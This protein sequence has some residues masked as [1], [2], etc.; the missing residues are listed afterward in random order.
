MNFFR[1]IIVFTLFGLF[2]NSVF[3]Q[4]PT[5]SEVT[6]FCSDD[7]NSLIFPNTTNGGQ[8]E[9]G[10]NY[11]CLGSTPNP[12]WYYLQID[13]PGD[14]DFN[15]VQNSQPDFSGF[16]IDVDFIAY[17]PFT[18]IDVCNGV[19]LSAANTI[20][21]SFSAAAVENFTINNAEPDQIYILLIT[22]F[23]NQPGFIQLQQTNAGGADDGS[24]DCSI[25]NPLVF[26]EGDV[27][28]LDATTTDAVTY[29]WTQ[30]GNPLAE[31]G[32][33]LNN[34]MAP[35]AVYEVD[36][37]NAA[38]DVIGEIQFNVNFE[39]IPSVNPFTPPSECDNNDDGVYE[40][41]FTTLNAI[42]TG[43]Q[44][45][46]EIS[47]HDSLNDAEMDMD[48]ITGIYTTTTTTT[49]PIFIRIENTNNA[50]CYS[51][52]SFQPALLEAPIL[53]S[54]LDTTVCSDEASGIVLSV[55]PASIVATSYNVI[56]INTNGLVASS[57]LPVVGNGLLA[58]EIIDD[59]Y[60]NTTAGPVDVIYTIVPVS[61][62]G[63]E[64]IPFDVNITVNPEP[65]LSNLD[66]AVCTDTPSDIILDVAMGS[67][68]A[69]SY[70][71]TTINTNGLVASSGSPVVGNGF[72][73]NEIVDD[74]YT[75]SS[76]IPVVVIYTIVPVSA[77]GCEGSAFNINLTINPEPVLSTS[78]DTT[79]CS[80]EISGVMLDVEV[81][82]VVAASYDITAINTNGLVASLGLPVV[83]NG[84][85]ANEIADDAYT[86]TTGAPVI[87]TYTIVPVS[88][89]NCDG[90][91]FDVNL[92]INPEPV[93][94]SAL[95][96][97]ICSDVSSGL[98]LDVEMGSAVA[99]TYNII[100]IIDN[101]LV[102]S[103]GVPAT[104][105]NFDA[106]EIADD[107][108]TNTIGA[109]V[110]VVYTIVPVSADGC[111]GDPLDIS[112]TINPEPV[113]STS[114]DIPVCSEFPSSLMLDVTSGS[115][116]ASSYNIIAINSNGLTASGGTPVVGNGFNAD[117]IA[118]DVYIN[119]TNTPVVVTYTIVPVSTDTCEGD[120]FD[121]NLTINPLP[122]ITN[123][124]E[125]IQ[126][127]NDTDGFSDFNLTEA[128]VL[129][130]AN[131]AN[132][133]FTYHFS[134]A[135]AE[136]G[137]GAIP[138][139]TVYTNT[140]PSSNPDTLYVRVENA[141]ACFRVAQLDL[142]VS[143]TQIPA[144]IEILY[145]IC[146]VGNVDNDIT[147]GIETFDFS[148]AEAQIRAQA[149]LP[150]GQNL[151]FTYYETGADALAETNA[152]PDISNYRNTTAGEQEIWVRVDGDIDNDCVGL[153]IHVR[154][155]T[156]N[157]MPNLD[158]DPIILCDDVT[159]GDLSEEFNLTI[160][161]SFI[162]N[163]DIDVSATYHTTFNGAN[164]AD[165]SIPNPTAYIN[166]NP[167]ETIFVRVT[168]NN[169][170]CYAIVE[171]VIQVN[172]LPDANIVVTDLSECEND[173][174]F[175]FDFD[176][177]SK[178]SE[179]LNGQDP[180]VFVV[181]YHE[182]PQEADD[183]ANPLSS[184]YTNIT[185]P[186]PIY[187]AITNTITGCSVSTL[188][189]NTLVFNIEVQESAEAAD[190][191]YELCDTVNENDGS[192]QFNL[193]SRN[194]IILDGQDPADFTVSYH[195]SEADAMNNEN[196]L[197]LLYENI[198][199]PQVIYTRVSSNIRPDECFDTSELT[200]QV[201][202]LPVINLDDEYILCL[203][204]NEAVVPIPPLL[205]T[206]LSD[207][208]Y[209]F[210]WSLDG[211]AL[212]LE[213]GSV[214][215]PT[216]YGGGE[217]MVEVTDISTSIVT[218]CVN[219]D[220]TQVIESGI[221]D[222]FDVQV[223]SLS[224]T[225]NNTITAVASGNSIYEFSLDQGPFQSSGEFQDVTGGEHIVY[226]RDVNGCGI[227]S[228][229]ITIIDYPKFFTPNGDGNNDTWQIQGINAQPDAIIY[230]HDRYG[231]L[232]KQLSPTS[233]GW[234]GTYNGNRMPTDDYW[235][236]LEY[237]EQITNERKTFR[238]HFTLKR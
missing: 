102:A 95:D 80:D 35:S 88:A 122:V 153:G 180:T 183:L 136:N 134:Q 91:P 4:G 19:Q 225:G 174:D 12:A 233:S 154:L 193:D 49:V 173:T 72:T 222:V 112:I 47:Y 161:E 33:I 21:C 106:N 79:V 176:L 69:A 168:N 52:G 226:V 192:T 189:V 167:V 75:N 82:S 191:F 42:I 3:S 190:D 170:G 10:P 41:D 8:A 224:F 5:C 50:D 113:L 43:G 219:T 210:V 197:P 118:D 13:Q 212:T 38:G 199:N 220:T 46:V 40:F 85:A 23:D 198:T 94:S 24:T 158:P 230:I 57:G 130:S 223:T 76:N 201:N 129:I 133:T 200:L 61:A 152:I 30:D 115:V 99:V 55:A 17:G 119:N 203:S 147:N 172:P 6:A 169:T 92:T 177:E 196:P 53:S 208:D 146:D 58:N 179:I 83:G 71:I 141:E 103:A 86:N 123:M 160:R 218:M 18:S 11:G 101:G 148:D 109:P 211:E 20:A 104:G 206:G 25:V 107:A 64:G 165:N 138:N 29:V 231:K 120:P 194:S 37:I 128:N 81:G 195:F 159:I 163:G 125:L 27:E 9:I 114:L 45:D 214:L 202:L 105:T 48:P 213:T 62:N 110:D 166:A 74:A 84:F 28:S 175:I 7:S 93:L 15:I 207:D 54:T 26:C 59:S 36:A 187:V 229:P 51:T 16:E 235:F 145:E 131:A 215:D 97:T 111:E 217:Y 96:T 144:D 68:A 56:A 63:C 162:F 140:D 139:P 65:I 60:T 87:V 78:L 34:V 100:N 90:I 150:T 236:V 186:Q 209:S 237:R 67:V 184:P 70:N 143:A 171:L 232:L 164:I 89:D 132:E 77:A 149:G 127:D 39:S 228:R 66:T 135:D 155:R 156:I 116:A 108:Y 204:D 205:D 181:S 126:C 73:A 151:T 2:T 234:D 1:K 22:N 185:N 121:V 188:S 216:P 137:I 44:T 182:S 14:L 124:V 221:P 31:T 157:P 227:L 178:T 32:A 98:T 142:L 117:E 238:A